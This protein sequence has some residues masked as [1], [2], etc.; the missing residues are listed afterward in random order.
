MENYLS[1]ADSAIPTCI[2]NNISELISE[3][4]GITS[5]RPTNVVRTHSMT[6]TKLYDRGVGVTPVTAIQSTMQSQREDMIKNML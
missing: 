4:H 5:L 1:A 2:S 6:D 3:F